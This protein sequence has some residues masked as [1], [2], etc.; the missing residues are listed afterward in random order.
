METIAMMGRYDLEK[1]KNISKYL[2]G[3]T[4]RLKPYERSMTPVTPRKLLKNFGIS[5]K[6]Q[7]A[8]EEEE[9]NK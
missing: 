1:L 6:A 7:V 3:I 8:K 2:F 5:L 9:K 4:K